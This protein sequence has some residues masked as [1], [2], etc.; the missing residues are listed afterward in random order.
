MKFAY[1]FR[2]LVTQIYLFNAGTCT[3]AQFCD[4]SYFRANALKVRLMPVQNNMYSKLLYLLVKTA[5][6]QEDPSAKTREIDR[7]TDQQ[8]ASVINRVTSPLLVMSNAEH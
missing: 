7:E 2:F 6:L 1:S 5:V 4:H 8:E 3:R